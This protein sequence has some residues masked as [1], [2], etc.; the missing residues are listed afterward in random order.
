MPCCAL[1]SP[2][3]IRS[4]ALLVMVA[5]LAHAALQTWPARRTLWQLSVV[6]G[7]PSRDLLRGVHPSCSVANTITESHTDAFFSGGRIWKKVF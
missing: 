7:Q 4:S 2:A 3:L 5:A 1:A 6:L